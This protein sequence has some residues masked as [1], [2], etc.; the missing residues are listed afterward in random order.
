MISM[1]FFMFLT[2]F[3]AASSRRHFLQTL[4]SM[5][6]IIAKIDIMIL[7]SNPLTATLKRI[8]IKQKEQMMKTNSIK[9]DN[10]L[11]NI[12]KVFEEMDKYIDY[13]GIKGKN[14]IHLRLLTEEAVGMLKEMVG[15]FTADFY[16][17]GDG[18]KN[19]I[20]IEG[21]A[22]LDAWQRSDL[23]DVSS[24][25]KNVLATGIMSKIRSVMEA[26]IMGIDL[27]YETDPI[28]YGYILSPIPRSE[29]ELF[30]QMW[31]LSAYRQGVENYRDDNEVNAKAWDEL[32]KSIV[33]NLADDVQV[34]I[35]KGNIKIVI[36]YNS[37]KQ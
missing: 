25:G 10:G 8:F 28:D 33:S 22:D 4:L 16:V 7:A 5:V 20:N 27:A 3:S 14:A 2:S 6:V 34:G 30:E 21:K 19:A 35:L 23:L 9:I 18:R 31:S 1:Y 17:E 12:E 32:E 11:G 36:V 15:S 37:K 13:N 24:S 29:G 26:G